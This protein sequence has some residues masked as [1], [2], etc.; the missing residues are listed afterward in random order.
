MTD[1]LCRNQARVRR[2]FGPQSLREMEVR[3]E[4][5]K[6][7][8]RVRCLQLRRLKKTLKRKKL[9]EQYR[10][11]GPRILEKRNGAS[12]TV[13][14]QPSADQ[15][16]EYWNGVLGVPGTHSLEDPAVRAW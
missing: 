13:F 11:L 3:L 2:I 12:S 10:C 5:L 8:L 15:V 9:N 4:T 6:G 7:C 16:T 14:A 1:R